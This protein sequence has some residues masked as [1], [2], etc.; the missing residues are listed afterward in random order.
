MY[1]FV[2]MHVLYGRIYVHMYVAV[3]VIQLPIYLLAVICSF[4][5]MYVAQNSGG[6]KL[7][8]FVEL[9]IIRQYFTQ[10]SLLYH[11]R[12]PDKKFACTTTNTIDNDTHTWTLFH[13]GY[14]TTMVSRGQTPSSQGTYRLEI[15]STQSTRD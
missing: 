10:P 6:G 9:H 13:H 4:I 3:Y 15:I 8:E 1:I 7:G 5:Y 12:L 14:R 2:C 11:P